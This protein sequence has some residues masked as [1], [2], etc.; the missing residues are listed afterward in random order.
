MHPFPTPW[1]T[2]SPGRAA[3][4]LT[5]RH[6][7]L[8]PDGAEVRTPRRSRR[9][10]G[11][12]TARWSLGIAQALCLYPSYVPR[13]PGV[14]VRADQ[15]RRRSTPTRK[16][17]RKS[18]GGFRRRVE[19]NRRRMEGNRRRLAGNRRR[20]EGNRRR[21]AGNR[22]RLEGNRRRLAGNRRRL[23]GNRR[24]L[25]SFER[26]RR[27]LFCTQEK[28]GSKARDGGRKGRPGRA[29]PLRRPTRCPWAPCR[30]LSALAHTLA[31]GGLRAS[32]SSSKSTGA[33]G[34]SSAFACKAVRRARRIARGRRRRAAP[35]RSGPGVKAGLVLGPLC[36]RAPPPPPLPPKEG[37]LHPQHSPEV[38]PH[39]AT[40]NRKCRAAR[41]R[42]SSGDGQPSAVSDTGGL[43]E[44]GGGF[45]SGPP[46]PRG[47]GGGSGRAREGVGEGYICC[48]GFGARSASFGAFWMYT[49]PEGGGGGG[50]STL[51]HRMGGG[52]G[53]ML[54]PGPQRPQSVVPHCSPSVWGWGGGVRRGAGGPG[55]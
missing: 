39:C 49:A 27:A 47:V 55:L 31:G 36:P 25:S 15:P 24:R 33:F 11:P 21:L 48:R 20:L 16:P 41:D 1:A 19:D 8:P 32:S 35:E 2:C 10:E 50:G 54:C 40:A 34:L 53:G 23:E 46:H 45:G 29:V 9:G 14:Q 6:R 37:H 38:W 18:V 26:S 51:H 44:G 13:P 3:L 4:S 7:R 42:R 5:G 17:M 52:G 43:G 30:T 28:A 22:R 12:T